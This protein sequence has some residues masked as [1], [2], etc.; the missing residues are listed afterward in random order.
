MRVEEVMTRGV[1]TVA[2]TEPA[3][4][5]LAR[6]RT[7]GIHHL[8][9]MRAREL[10]GVVSKRDVGSVKGR[11]VGD[12]MARH[13]VA[14]TSDMTIRKAASLLRGRNIGCLPV[15]DDGKLV[16]IVTSTDLLERIGH[17][18]RRP[19]ATGKRW[20][21]KGRGPRRKSVVGH[22]GFAAH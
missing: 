11:A 19:A 6:M 17:A 22:K 16:G 4:R 21:L 20:I 13:V 5:A 12:V 15:V 1:E 8:V 3:E 2:A 9:V 14:A 7:G 10:V 18:A